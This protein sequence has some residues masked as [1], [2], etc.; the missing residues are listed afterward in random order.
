MCHQV[1]KKTLKAYWSKVL[2]EPP[3]KINSLS[4]LADKTELDKF[5]TEE[6]LAL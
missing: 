2:E 6:Q 3:L 4:R 5:M 1:I